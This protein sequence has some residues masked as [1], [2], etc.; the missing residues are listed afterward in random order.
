M[1]LTIYFEL[2]KY[3]LSYIL[4]IILYFKNRYFI[5]VNHKF[6]KHIYNV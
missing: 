1:L 6:V 3:Y 2:N 5:N 4:L